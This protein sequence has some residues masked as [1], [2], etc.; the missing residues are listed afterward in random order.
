MVKIIHYKVTLCQPT[1]KPAKCNN[2]YIRGQIDKKHSYAT[3]DVATLVS[4]MYRH[5]PEPNVYVE[6]EEH[7]DT[8]RSPLKKV[9]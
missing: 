1:R 2:L 9:P 5:E 4:S 6:P 8:A 7:P 3:C